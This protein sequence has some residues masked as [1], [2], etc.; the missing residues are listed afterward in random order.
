MKPYLKPKKK[1]LENKQTKK[2]K[3]EIKFNRLEDKVEEIS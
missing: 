2:V 1:L 3:A